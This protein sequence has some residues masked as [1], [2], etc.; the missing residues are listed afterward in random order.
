MEIEKTENDGAVTLK[1]GGRLDTATSPQFEKE[2]DGVLAGKPESLILDFSGLE[3]TSS[4]GLRV[5]LKTQK[6]MNKAGGKMKIVNAC[7][8]VREVF[9]ITGFIDIIDLE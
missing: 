1:V 3:Y 7:D 8:A 6:E 9:S 5:I 4:A 2:I